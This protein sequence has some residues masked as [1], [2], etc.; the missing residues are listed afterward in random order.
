MSLLYREAAIEDIDALLEL[1]RECFAQPMSRENLDYFVRGKTSAVLVAV[2]PSGEIAAY[3]S[4]GFV[5][6]EGYIGNVCT[7]KKYRRNGAA[8]ALLSLARERATDLGLSFLTLEVRASNAGAIALYERAG[9]ENVGTRPGY[10][11]RPKEDAVIMTLS[12]K[13]EGRNGDIGN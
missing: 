13:G 1:E 3:M 11:E 7:R 2:V 12:L 5:L 8:L 9:Y 6:D 4:F 10:Y